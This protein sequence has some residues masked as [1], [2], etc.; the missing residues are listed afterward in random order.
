MAPSNPTAGETRAPKSACCAHN[1]RSASL[2]AIKRLG[3]VVAAQI[4]AEER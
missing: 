1:G 4:V 3:D 2:P